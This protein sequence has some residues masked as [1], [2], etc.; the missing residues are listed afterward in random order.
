MNFGFFKST[1]HKWGRNIG[2]S[3]SF[4]SR[5][6]KGLL[7]VIC[8]MLLSLYIPPVIEKVYLSELSASSELRDQA[9]LKQWTDS[10][11][12]HNIIQKRL[13]KTVKKAEVTLSKF[14]PNAATYEELVTLG[15]SSFVSKNILSYRNKGGRFGNKKDLLKIYGIDSA[16]VKNNLWPYI[17]LP[18]R[19]T[20]KKNNSS[21][22][23]ISIVKP[24]Y[25][26]TEKAVLKNLNKAS[27]SDLQI[28]K[29]IGPWY[30]NCI[31]EYRKQLG[32]FVQ[33]SQIQEKCRLNHGVLNSLRNKF[34]I[35]RTNINCIDLN[36]ASIEVLTRHPYISGKLASQIVL[37][38]AHHGNFEELQSLKNIK[39][40][41]DQVY[42]RVKPYL[43]VK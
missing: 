1:W 34:H 7:V 13:K 11:K 8:F 29:G 9:I 35:D 2:K 37:Y 19:K 16:M 30:A 14:D 25:T 43:L 33:F 41:S 21:K 23:K 17:N 31:C 10:L 39:A 12:A 26:K 36:T 40:I 22:K 27:D 42:Q 18:E 15:F 28:V 20:T 5:E 24:I 32:G 38:R 3:I 4:S 6:S